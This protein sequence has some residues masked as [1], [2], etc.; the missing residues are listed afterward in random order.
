MTPEEEFT[1]IRAAMDRHD[2]PD[3]AALRGICE[4]IGYG[5]VIQL[6]EEWMEELHPGHAAASD[7]VA[8]GR[9]RRRLRERRAG[10]AVKT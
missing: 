5:H 2:A 10:K 7:A 6:A 9:H 4:R 3:I 8:A 1:K